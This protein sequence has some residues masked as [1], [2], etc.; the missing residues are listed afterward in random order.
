MD[1]TRLSR[2]VAHAA[3]AFGARRGDQ[4]GPDAVRPLIE[5]ARH[6]ARGSDLK[7]LTCVVL[8]KRLKPGARPA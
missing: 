6:Y 2:V 4:P 8:S 7:R 3:I 1:G 5:M